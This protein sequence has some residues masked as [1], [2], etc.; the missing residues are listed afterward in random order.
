MQAKG[1]EPVPE[2]EAHDAAEKTAQPAEPS[3]MEVSTAPEE[4]QV[5][6]A[7]ATAEV[8]LCRLMAIVRLCIPAMGLCCAHGV[9]VICLSHLMPFRRLEAGLQ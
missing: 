9:H 5:T 3:D 2:Q 6:N 8:V 1:Q 4:S 7:P